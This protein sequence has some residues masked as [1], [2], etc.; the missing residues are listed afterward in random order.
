MLLNP[1][2]VLLL[3]DQLMVLLLINQLTG[4]LHLKQKPQKLPKL[5]KLR[6]DRITLLFT[7]LLLQFMPLQLQPMQH[8]HRPMLHQSSIDRLFMQLRKQKL[9]KPRK[10]LKLKPSV[11]QHTIRPRCLID[12]QLQCDQFMQLHPKLKLPRQ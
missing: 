7:P 5:P 12:H 9:Q 4:L 6:N 10:L 11:L 2:T 8:L 1:P 3:L